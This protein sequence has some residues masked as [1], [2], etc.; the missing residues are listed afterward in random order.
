MSFKYIVLHLLFENFISVYNIFCFYSPP[1][2]WLQLFL[3]SDNLSLSRLLFVIT[4]IIIL[5]LRLI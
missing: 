1:T 3:K 4:I 5:I 2:A